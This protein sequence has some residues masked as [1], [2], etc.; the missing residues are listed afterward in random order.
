[1]I[2]NISASDLAN[3]MSMMRSVFKGT[4]LVVEG[5]T[6]YRLYGKFADRDKVRIVIAHSKDNVRR[7]VSECQ[8][9]R[10]DYA[11]IGIA[12]KDLDGMRGRKR[13]PPVFE[14]DR[15]DMESSI[16]S[17]HA[18]DD[19]LAEYSDQKKLEQ[20]E[21][22][23][24]KVYDVLGRAA[25]PICLLMYIS[26]RRG[27]NLSFKDLDHERFVNSR[28]L[29]TD[30]GRMV[31]AVYAQSMGQM[32]PKAMIAD[33]I[34]SMMRNLDDPWDS[35]RGHDAVDILVLGLHEAFG[36]YNAKN[37]REGELGGALRLA[38]SYEYFKSTGLYQRS[39][40]WCDK[41]RL[42]LWVS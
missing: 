33:Q 10:R 24:G 2:E 25:C 32:Y 16:L 3:E 31:G 37:I 13:S 28:T 7:S 38:Y 36:A 6:D 5:V 4:F 14:T 19:V 30:I 35:V 12:D 41:H 40:E 20:F 29:E 18:L 17:S 27:M 9:K 26:Y 39:K 22:R 21:K 11:V 42:A 8:V 15:N 1:M 23:H 34:R